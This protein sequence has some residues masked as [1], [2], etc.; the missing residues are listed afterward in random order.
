MSRYKLIERN[1]APRKNRGLYSADVVRFQASEK[2]VS[3]YSLDG[4]ILLRDSLTSLEAEFPGRFFRAHPAHL[5]DVQRITRI[6]V[7]RTQVDGK[8]RQRLH[9]ELREV[10]GL[11]PLGRRQLRKLL[12][13]RPDL[14]S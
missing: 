13:R 3:A 5:V 12:E 14:A 4:E 6:D 9:V 11:V 1:Q 2:Y 8:K 7:Q 10:P